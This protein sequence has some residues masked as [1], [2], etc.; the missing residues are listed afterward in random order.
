[1]ATLRDYLKLHLVVFLWG[2]TAVMAKLI[3]IPAIE[4]LF[5]RTWMSA[6]GLFIFAW[7]TKKSLKLS[8]IGVMK[9]C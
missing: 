7:I 3:T 6:V 1:M 8:F 5:H 2:T 4:M 9:N